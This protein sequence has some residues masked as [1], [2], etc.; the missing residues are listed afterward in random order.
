MYCTQCGEKLVDTAKFCGSCGYNLSSSKSKSQ[1]ADERGSSTFDKHLATE[2]NFVSAELQNEDSP[3]IDTEII[4]TQDKVDKL[5]KW[6]IIFSILWLA[7]FGSLLAFIFG[8]KAKG[9]ISKS[10][11][12]VSGMGR[13]QWCLVVGVLGMLF[14]FPII[15][16]GAISNVLK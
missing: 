3:L 11:G 7:G 14:W 15:F 2:D 10:N 12:E 1:E 13:A 9:L 5:L 6:G 4:Q 8:L 16:F